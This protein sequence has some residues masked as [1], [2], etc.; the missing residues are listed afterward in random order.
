MLCAAAHDN[1]STSRGETAWEA[2]GAIR[3][4]AMVLSDRKKKIH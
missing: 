3:G 2:H 1:F 4:L